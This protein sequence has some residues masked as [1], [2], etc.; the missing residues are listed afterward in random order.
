M[1]ARMVGEA[2]LSPC[3]SCDRLQAPVNMNELDK[4]KK[5][6]NIMKILSLQSPLR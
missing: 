2:R 4:Q 6:D 3:D 1:H 5:K